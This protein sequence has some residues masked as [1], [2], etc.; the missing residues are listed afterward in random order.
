MTNT[1]NSGTNSLAC[2]VALCFYLLLSPQPSAAK[3]PPPEGRTYFTVS[4]GLG[5][6]FHGADELTLVPGCL[7]FTRD[8]ICDLAGDCNGTWARSFGGVQTRK[9]TSFTFVFFD[10]GVELFN[11]NARVDRRGRKHTF[12]AAATILFEGERNNFG[13]IGRPVKPD[14]CQELVEQFYEDGG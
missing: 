2:L 5:V 9:Q 1:G 6:V 11:G 14:R 4:M 7:R 3:P 8:Q 13:M 12:A 10:D